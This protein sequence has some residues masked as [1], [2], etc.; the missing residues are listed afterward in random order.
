MAKP[1]RRHREFNRHEWLVSPMKELQFL[2][3]IFL[4]VLLLLAL[5]QFL[6]NRITDNFWQKIMQYHP[7][8]VKANEFLNFSQVPCEVIVDN[9]VMEPEHEALELRHNAVFIIAWI[10]DQRALSLGVVPGQVPSAIIQLVAK[11]EI[12]AAVVVQLRLVVRSPAVEVI[13]IK[14]RRSKVGQGI[15]VTVLDQG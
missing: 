14:S 1:V 5:P 12:R 8:I 10:S 13:Q 11:T 3:A 7:L 4:L 15:R 9:P 2:S 6:Q